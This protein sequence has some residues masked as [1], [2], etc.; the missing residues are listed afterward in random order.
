MSHSDSPYYLS[1]NQQ[2]LL[3]AT[4]ASNQPSTQDEAAGRN[5]PSRA[6]VKNEKEN[7]ASSRQDAFQDSTN[8][9]LNASPA[10]ASPPIGFDLDADGD[11]Q[12]DFDAPGQFF[13][14]ISG[15]TSHNDSNELHEKRK[16]VGDKDDGDEGGGKRRESEG[17]TGKKPGRKPLTA[18]PTTVSYLPQAL[19]S[20]C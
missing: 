20:P 19:L 11:D 12:Y 10:D 2:D 4:L 15:E 14:D 1:P 6:I 13:G 17:A 9:Y 7:E 16:A 8:D 3:V 18:E 5:E